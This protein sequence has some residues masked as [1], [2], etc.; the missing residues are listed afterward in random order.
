MYRAVY[1]K[2]DGFTLIEVLI[3]TAI[4]GLIG[5]GL[6]IAVGQVINVNAISNS[7]VVAVKQVENAAYWLNRD[8]RMAQIIEPNGASGFPLNLSWVEWDNTT[9]QVSY[10]LVNDELK[11]SVSV[12]GTGPVV[13][14]VAQHISVSPDDTL[15][16]YNN[17]VLN[18]KLTASVA[19]FRPA[20]EIRFAQVT[21]RAAQ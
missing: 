21:P 6:S 4:I 5:A 9:C 2:P 14:K 18:F 3:A 19:G 17:G 12:N 11:R 13:M 10:T 1:T 20:R 8:V 7:H 16:Q 15:C